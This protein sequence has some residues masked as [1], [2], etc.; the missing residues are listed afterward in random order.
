MGIMP[1][2]IAWDKQFSPWH[3]CTC[4]SGFG[5]SGCRNCAANTLHDGPDMVRMWGPKGQRTIAAE[6]LWQQPLSWDA[7]AQALGVRQ[8]VLCAPMADIFEGSATLPVADWPSVTAARARLWDLI[9][10]TPHLDWMLLT[11]RPELVMA[12]IPHRWSLAGM[13]S[14]VWVGVSVEHQ[15]AADARI[16]VLLRIPARIRFVICAPLLRPIDMIRMPRPGETWDWLT[17]ERTDCRSQMHT[18]AI[19]WV[20]VGGETGPL[21]RPM[22]PDWARSLRDQCHSAGTPFTFMG[23]GSW[24]PGDL[25]HDTSAQRTRWVHRL[26]GGFVTSDMPG[27]AL[28]YDTRH[29]FLSFADGDRLLDGVAHTASPLL[30][31]EEQ[32]D[33]SST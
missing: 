10:A 11:K 32:D 4:V 3:G 33:A 6:A 13:P 2:T 21:A 28:M 26:D 22:H 7:D 17:G 5:L 14:H 20:I 18:A 12:L 16:P 24:H 23:W 15:A 1:R 29:M 8:R 30:L 19:D 9:D 25:A 27:A 31:S